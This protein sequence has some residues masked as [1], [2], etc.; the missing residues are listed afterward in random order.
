MRGPLG[1]FPIAAVLGA[2]IALGPGAQAAPTAIT[3]C[4][5]ISQPGPYVLANDIFSPANC[6]VITANDTIDLA[7]FQI[8]SARGDG[9]HASSASGITVRNGSIV[10]GGT[11]VY[12]AGEGSIV[13][14]CT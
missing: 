8:V 3:A 10:G 7:G 11:G 6:L 4:Q 13:E 2:T 14:D 5:T 1:L 12:L 9:I